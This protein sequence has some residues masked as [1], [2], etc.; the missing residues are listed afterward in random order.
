LATAHWKR[1]GCVL[2]VTTTAALRSAT[3]KSTGEDWLGVPAL[4]RELGVTATT[5][6][7]LLDSGEL[8]AYKI[9]R[10]I[11][12]RRSDV[13]PFLQ[14]V[15]IKPGELRHLYPPGEY[16]DPPRRR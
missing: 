1:H 5:L 8:P 14:R 4:A 11:R 6:Y 16:G 13:Q 12:I 10:V 7:R 3:V 2:R 9:G 15:K